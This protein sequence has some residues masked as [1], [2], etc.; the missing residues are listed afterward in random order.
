[1]EEK[2]KNDEIKIKCFL[3]SEFSKFSKQRFEAPK[4]RNR[5]K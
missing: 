2:K 5:I 3:R 1:M 4:Q